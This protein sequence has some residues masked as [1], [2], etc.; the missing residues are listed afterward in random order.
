MEMFDASLIQQIVR[1]KRTTIEKAL[2]LNVV[3]GESI[4][5]LTELEEDVKFEA[6][7]RG[8]KYTILIDKSTQSTVQ[9]NGDFANSDNSVSQNLINIIIK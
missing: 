7:F 1:F 9:L 5:V 6:G 3:S 4:Y 8:G 2:G